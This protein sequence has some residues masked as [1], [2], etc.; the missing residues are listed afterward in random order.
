VRILNVRSDHVSLEVLSRMSVKL[1]LRTRDNPQFG[2]WL[3]VSE[4]SVL[5]VLQVKS[6]APVE[7]C[8]TTYQT[9]W[10]YV[11]KYRNLY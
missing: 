5:S 6:A 8:V 9:T 11:S 1:L 3:P 7:T 2:R 4:R 10:D